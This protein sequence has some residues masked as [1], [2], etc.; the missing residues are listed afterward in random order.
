LSS[1]P[2]QELS[3]SDRLVGLRQAVRRPEPVG[4]AGLEPAPVDVDL[5]VDEL[6][7]FPGV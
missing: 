3:A 5:V 6:E 2:G 4:V 7:V 1:S